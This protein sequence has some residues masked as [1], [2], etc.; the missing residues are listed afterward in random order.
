M[1]DDLA[2]QQ[3]QEEVKMWKKWQMMENYCQV[4]VQ[5]TA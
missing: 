2:I 5:K 4:T 1:K 3:F